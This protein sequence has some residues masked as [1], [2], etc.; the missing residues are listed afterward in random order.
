MMIFG[1]EILRSGMDGKDAGRVDGQLAGLGF[2]REASPDTI[3]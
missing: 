3:L 2:G 1:E